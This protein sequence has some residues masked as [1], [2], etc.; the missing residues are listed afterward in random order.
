[1]T[2]ASQSCMCPWHHYMCIALTRC[3]CAPIYRYVCIPFGLFQHS[4]CFSGLADTVA[5]A[6]VCG[7]T[8][9][10]GYESA[11]ALPHVCSMLRWVYEPTCRCYS[12]TGLR[13]KFHTSVCIRY[14]TH[15]RLY[16]CNTIPSVPDMVHQF[17]NVRV[18]RPFP[19]P[20]RPL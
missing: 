7:S 14:H 18:Q 16:Y 9:A 5:L 3:V 19:L 17:Y 1:M 4:I 13:I 2:P 6:I 12:T 20:S 10:L 15:K 11:L 8:R